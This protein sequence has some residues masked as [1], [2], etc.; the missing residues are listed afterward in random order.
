MNEIYGQENLQSAYQLAAHTFETVY[1]ENL[2]DG[3]FKSTT[4]PNQAQLGPT[5]SLVAED[6]NKD[7]YKDIMGIGAIYDAEVETIRYDSNFGYVLLGNG[8]GSFTYNKNYDPFI[9]SDAKDMVQILIKDKVH[10]MVVSNNA[11]ISIFN[12]KS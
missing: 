4:L 7:G 2:G 9:K 3:K 1:L 11:P 6:F 12:F 5:M 8:K 10:Y